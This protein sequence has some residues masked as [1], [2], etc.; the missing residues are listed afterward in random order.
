[1][2]S[3]KEIKLSL[4]LSMARVYTP[5]RELQSLLM[6]ALTLK[7]RE[8]LPNQTKILFSPKLHEKNQ[9]SK[10]GNYFLKSIQL[11][12]C[13]PSYLD[14]SNTKRESKVLKAFPNLLSL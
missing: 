4:F 6:H 3:S 13:R 1:M 7:S 9:K 8:K 14:L 11:S 5:N 12:G 10:F 2:I